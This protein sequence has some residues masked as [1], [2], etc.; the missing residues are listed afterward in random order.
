[1][2]GRFVSR[3]LALA[4][5]VAVATSAAAQAASTGSIAGRVTEADGGKPAAGVRVQAVAGLRVAAVVV[6][7]EDGRYRIGGLA[8]GTYA[9]VAMRIGYVAKRVEGVAVRAGGTTTTDIAVTQSAAAL[10]EVVTTASRGAAEEKVLSAPASISVVSSEQMT[11]RPSTTIASQMKSV[12]GVAVSQGGLVQTNITSR[13]FNNAFSTSMLMLQ[14]YR[15]TNV[16]SLRANIPFLFTGTTEDIERIEILNGPAAALY[17]PNSA[18]GVMHIITKSPFNSQGTSVTVDGGSQS[19]IRGAFRTAGTFA[20]NTWGYKLSGEYFKGVDFTY[21]D[22]NEPA[23]YPTLSY[24]DPATN[25]ATPY[26]RSGQTAS[27]DENVNRYSTEA[28]LDYRPN[29][30]F[31]N[32]LTGGYTKVGSAIELTTAFGASQVKNWAYSSIQDRVRYKKFFAQVFLNANNSGN[33]SPTDGNGTFYLRTGIPVVDKSTVLT[34][35]MQQAFD[36]AGDKYV[37]GADYISTHPRS[38]GSIFGKNEGN[39]DIL[40]YGAYLQGTNP[41]TKKLDLVWA[42]RADQTDRLNG[43]QFSPRVAFSY[44]QSETNNFRFTFSRAFNSPASFSYFLDQVSSTNVAPGGF[45]VYAVGNPPKEG[46]QFARSCDATING[47]LCMH[48]PFYGN[49]NP[50]AFAPASATAAYSEFV[51]NWLNPIVAGLPAANFGG[52][53][54]KAQFQAILAGVAIPVMNA[55]GPPTATQVGSVMRIGSAAVPVSSIQ[56]LQPLQASFNNTWELGWKTIIKDKLRIAL[57]L[58]YQVRGDVGIPIGQAN[59]LVFYDPATL[60]GYLQGKLAAPLAQAFA[61]QGVPAAAIPGAISQFLT[62]LTTVMA[63]LPQGAVAFK[64]TKLAGDQSIIA[65]YQAPSGSLDVRGLDLAVDY[66]A[67][68]KWLF[69]S[70]LSHIGQIVFPTVGGDINPLMSNSPKWRASGSV[71]YMNETTGWS[72]DGTVRYTDAFPVNSGLLNSLGIP[73]NPVG[74][75]LYP[76]VPASTQFDLGATWHLPTA[77]KIAWSLNVTNLLDTQ[78]ATFV[79]VPAI[80]RMIV[81]RVKYDF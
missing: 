43:T 2:V 6:S 5:F 79:G 53:A 16:P 61:A 36:L 13:G 39:T 68:D 75:A 73:P 32:I 17:G 19:L 67:N 11:N 57:D 22:P 60:G 59:P 4:A 77:A 9:V 72:W 37:V 26:P 33:D 10:N 76:P 31:E 58:W 69:A 42:A 64:N 78:A 28:R 50:T 18:N 29:Q 62:G 41:L 47:G 35:Q 55:S 56:D 34:A 66:Q 15:N 40:E 30:D 25:Q 44:K 71:H 8:A 23:T 14:D 45:N 54:G 48:S 51:K 63:Q 49:A 7:G 38:E 21:R 12:P 3:L 81:T 52:A 65:T 27:R 70:T 24:I 46:W 74:T 20:D 80:G 1:M